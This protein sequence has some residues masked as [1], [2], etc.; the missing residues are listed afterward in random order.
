MVFWLGFGALLN[1]SPQ[2]PARNSIFPD[3]AVEY[4]VYM[5]HL[6]TI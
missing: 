2:P 3:F 1:K 4:A 6:G 5:M